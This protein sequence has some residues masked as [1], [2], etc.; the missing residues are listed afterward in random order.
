MHEEAHIQEANWIKVQAAAQVLSCLDKQSEITIIVALEWLAAV[1]ARKGE[2]G[3]GEGEVD[4][5]P[6]PCVMKELLANSQ[7]D[8]E[9]LDITV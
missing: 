4:S 2:T 1:T 9:Q 6:A 7:P 3:K 5:V 8:G